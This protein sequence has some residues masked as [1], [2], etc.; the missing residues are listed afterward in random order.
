VATRRRRA[1]VRVLTPLA[2]DRLILLDNAVAEFI[3]S[4]P[5]RSLIPIEKRLISTAR[6]FLREL[7]LRE[8]QGALFDSGTRSADLQAMF[9]QLALAAGQAPP[10]APPPPEAPPPPPNGGPLEGIPP[11]VFR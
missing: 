1:I 8:S 10:P 6:A 4:L 7:K 11:G 5:D 2:G 9:E 3:A